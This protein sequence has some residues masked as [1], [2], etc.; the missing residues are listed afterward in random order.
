MHQFTLNCKQECVLSLL[1]TGHS[2]GQTGHTPVY[3]IKVETQK[4]L[5]PITIRLLQ[6]R[7]QPHSPCS[8]DEP[9]E[10]Y[11]LLTSQREMGL[12]VGPVVANSTLCNVSLFFISG[13][14][15]PQRFS[16]MQSSAHNLPKDSYILEEKWTNSNGFQ[17]PR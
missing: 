2:K 9:V 6:R 8:P 10:L 3:W 11:N 1:F 14:D 5:S 7:I 17:G 4:V 13:L 16:R 15:W 12:S